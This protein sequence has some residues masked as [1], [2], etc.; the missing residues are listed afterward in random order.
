MNYLIY[1][2]ITLIIIILLCYVYTKYKD[3]IN[4]YIVLNKL[5][6][7][8]RGRLILLDKDNNIIFKST[9]CIKSKYKGI[10]K[11]NNENEF[12]ERLVNHGEIGLGE[13]Y[14][15]NIWT[16]PDIFSTIMVLIE[17]EKYLQSS[18]LFYDTYSSI[19]KD[20]KNIQHHYDLG[21]D[22]YETFLT[23]DLKAY[24]CGFFF[25][26]SDTLN[27]A[28]Y[29]KV[30]KIIQKLNLNPNHTV[31]DVGCGWGQIA[32]YIQNKTKSKMYGITISKE[33]LKYINSKYH[34]V[35]ALLKH[36]G[37][38]ENG[39]KYDRIYSIGMFEHVR[40]TNYFKFFEKM[41]EILNPKGR[42]VLHTISK[43]DDN[44]AC[45]ESSSQCFVTK[46]IFPGGQIP[47]HEWIIDNATKAGFKII[48]VEIFGGM[49]YAKTLRE[50]R[51]NLVNN[52]E[53][54]LTLGY[55]MSDFRTYEYYFSVC[56]AAFLNNIFQVSQYVFDKVDNLS[57]VTHTAYDC[58]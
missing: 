24:S 34:N 22:F 35:K 51:K 50:W 44:V 56:E 4:K 33:Q 7:I 54:I 11:I 6:N 58:K 47:K 21:N 32:S 13:G 37:E 19:E 31:L 16:T 23:D 29:N 25:C 17:N 30:N 2:T 52:K 14:V 28:Q 38:I 26:P 20:Y 39:F 27:T 36:Y 57:D 10:I 43:I 18:S 48:H 9:P 40:C 12:F 53:R 1:I 5:S 49:H 46:H 55:T 8:K 15:D 41:Y 42:F 45:N 3:S